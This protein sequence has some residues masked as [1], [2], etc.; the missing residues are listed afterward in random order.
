ML[1]KYQ[2]A[3]ETFWCTPCKAGAQLNTSFLQSQNGGNA[4]KG[5]VGGAVSPQPRRC[6]RTARSL[7]M[8]DIVHDELH[9]QRGVHQLGRDDVVRNVVVDARVLLDVAAGAT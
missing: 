3:P 1:I 6:A 9:K 5:V 8:P 4:K 2:L 7:V